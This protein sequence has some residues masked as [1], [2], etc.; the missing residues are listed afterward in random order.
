M[1]EAGGDAFYTI[2]SHNK[3]SRHKDL[4]VVYYLAM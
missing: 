1:L 3:F 2:F 4:C